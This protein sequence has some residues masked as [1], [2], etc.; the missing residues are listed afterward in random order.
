MRKMKK[1]LSVLVA[2]TMTLAMAAPSFAAPVS[3]T[4]TVMIDN[5]VKGQEY[6]AYKLFDLSLS[7]EGEEQ[8]FAYT[9]SADSEWKDVFFSEDGGVITS[10]VAGLS[11]TKASTGDVYVVTVDEAVFDQDAAKSLAETLR[12]N[13]EGKTGVTLDPANGSTLPLGY[14]FVT[15]TTGTL[16]SLDT[17]QPDVEI[18]EKNEAPTIKKELTDADK[19][20]V[21]QI[22]H[23]LGYTV[24]I[25]VKAGVENVRGTG[26]YRD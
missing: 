18:K 3:T 19:D 26:V 11:F 12:G 22:G 5:P 7:G 17:T 24:T 21:A 23:V 6:V 20:T 8:N 15:S 14:Y 13:T 1:L 4:G 9:I 2:A 16:C 25:D 10:N